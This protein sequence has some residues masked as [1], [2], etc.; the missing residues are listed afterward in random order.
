MSGRIDY[1]KA[2]RRALGHRGAP[3]ED[4]TMGRQRALR[5]WRTEYPE[6]FPVTVTRMS[7]PGQDPDNSQPESEA[8]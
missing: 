7:T 8:A 1:G 3:D 6:E 2:K 5:G 4:S